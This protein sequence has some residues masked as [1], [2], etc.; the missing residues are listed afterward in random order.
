MR[1]SS[2]VD[3]EQYSEEDDHGDES[4]GRSGLMKPLWKRQV[5]SRHAALYCRRGDLS[6]GASEG[7]VVVAPRP[8]CV[9][10]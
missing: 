6:R 8:V 2:L 10:Q 5:G 1:L 7:D 3:A 4:E 9:G